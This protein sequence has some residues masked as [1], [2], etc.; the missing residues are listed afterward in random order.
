[1]NIQQMRCFTTVAELEN[2]SRAAELLHTSQS[3]LSKNIAKLEEEVGVPLF[4]RSG[5]KIELSA[6]GALFLRCCTLTLNHLDTALEEIRRSSGAA[7]HR[8]RIASAGVNAA[9]MRCIAAFSRTHP[10]TEFD[11]NSSIESVEH[12]DI[13]DFD[14]LIYP[15]GGRYEKFNGY[16]LGS[17]KYYLAVSDGHPLAGEGS[18]TLKRLEGLDYVFLRSGRESP[19][20]VYALCCALVLH[21]GA[22]CFADSR[23]LHRRMVAAGIAAGF[24]PEGEADGYRAD[25]HIHLLPIA[26]ARFARSMMICFKRDK[27]L[28]E[29]AREFRDYVIAELHLHME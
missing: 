15:G 12:L 18:V 23:E 9:M 8:I 25:A 1:M 5:K 27:H 21:F 6:A 16:P 11:L 2:M 3:S 26:D 19:E 22:L 29:R 20:P 24:V 17:E 14:V 28:S 10:G 7:D 13:N 4:Q